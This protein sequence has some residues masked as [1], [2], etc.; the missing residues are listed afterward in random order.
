MIKKLLQTAYWMIL[1]IGIIQTQTGVAKSKLKSDKMSFMSEVVVDKN[2][3]FLSDVLTAENIP[4]E[5]KPQFDKIRLGDAPQA[6]ETRRFT[7]YAVSEIIR[8]QLRGQDQEL[9]RKYS[10]S[11]PNEINVIRKSKFDIK[12]LEK[13]I[14]QWFQ[15]SCE[16][17]EIQIS[18]LRLPNIKD[19]SG[20]DWNLVV[21][22]NVPRGNFTVPVELIKNKKVEKTIWAQ[23]QVKII[24]TVPVVRRELSVGAKIQP[25]DIEY[26][27]KDIT[28]ERNSF[29]HE[30]EILGSEVAQNI[31]A[32]QIL[33]TRHLKRRLTLNK[34][35][36]VGVTMKSQGWKIYSKAVAQEN[37]YIGDYVKVQNPDTKRV[38]T[39]V[40]TADGTVEVK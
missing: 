7:N 35:T 11:I 26:T 39:G 25:E 32:N 36:S 27:K 24:K 38:L 29:P 17:C 19:F 33:L 6:G 15:K 2:D 34:G 14:T 10:F 18:S 23:G 12:D 1:I 31:G 3:I 13:A 22:N 16:D 20:Y 37:G 40:V 8:H 30:E 28:F 9:L 21:S 5:L 4:A